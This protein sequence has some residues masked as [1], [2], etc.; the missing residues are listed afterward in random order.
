ME[1]YLK[2]NPSLML[3]LFLFSN[4]L[5]SNDF[6]RLVINTFESLSKRSFTKEFQDLEPVKDMILQ[7][8]IIVTSFVIESTIVLFI[9]VTM[10]F[11]CPKTKIV[12]L[13]E[14]QYLTLFKV[15]Q[16]RPLQVVFQAFGSWYG[17][18]NLII[19]NFSVA[20]M[21]FFIVFSLRIRLLKSIRLKLSLLSSHLWCLTWISL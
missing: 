7:N 1:Q 8:Y 5:N 11:L 6:T 3:E 20:Q 18:L 4:N 19:W 14:I 21:L 10:Y 12:A 2:L 17:Q 13:F 9:L 15:C 16:L